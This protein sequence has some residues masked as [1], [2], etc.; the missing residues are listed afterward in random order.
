[1][2]GV[3]FVVSGESGPS[4]VLPQV[5]TDVLDDQSFAPCRQAPLDR[6]YHAR[7]A[8]SPG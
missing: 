7:V 3:Q 8:L 1:M 5:V 4:W 6:G 2:G